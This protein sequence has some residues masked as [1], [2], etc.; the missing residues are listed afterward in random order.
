MRERNA[1]LDEQCAIIGRD[2]QAITR[3]LYGWASMMGSDPWESPAA[4]SEII[5]VYRDAGVNEFL[6]DAPGEDR[7][8]V[9]EKIV[10]DVIPALRAS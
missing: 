5:G 10:A 3:S 1:I 6:L 4:F 9:L 7:F 8:P 2:P